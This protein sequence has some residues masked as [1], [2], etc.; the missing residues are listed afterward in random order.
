MLPP[1]LQVLQI[2]YESRFSNSIVYFL[3]QMFSEMYFSGLFRR[4]EIKFMNCLPYYILPKP[5]NAGADNV[6]DYVP[7]SW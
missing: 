7:C 1:S 5:M 4:N 3:P 2:K 6:V